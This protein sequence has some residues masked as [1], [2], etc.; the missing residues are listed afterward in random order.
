MHHVINP[1]A[2]YNPELCGL[3]QIHCTLFHE[4]TGLKTRMCD[5]GGVTYFIIPYPVW[6]LKW[7]AVPGLPTAAPSIQ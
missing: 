6:L 1:D 2:F 7:T 4:Q 5:I 3:G